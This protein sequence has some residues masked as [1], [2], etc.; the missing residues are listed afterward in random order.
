ML[1]HVGDV[2]AQQAANL[3]AEQNMF[4]ARMGQNRQQSSRTIPHQK[5]RDR[6]AFKM[7]KIYAKQLGLVAVF[8]HQVTG[9][10]IGLLTVTLNDK[11]DLLLHKTSNG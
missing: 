4:Y 8:L 1:Q 7:Q 11:L 2:R 9:Q 3:A 10:S 5:A 6:M